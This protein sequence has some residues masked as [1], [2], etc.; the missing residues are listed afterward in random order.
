MC[1]DRS[2][3]ARGATVIVAH[4]RAASRSRIGPALAETTSLTVGGTL[5]GSQLHP[6]PPCVLLELVE[7]VKHEH[8]APVRRRLVEGV[9][10]PHAEGSRIAGAGQ[11]QAQALVQLRQDAPHE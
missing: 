9:G 3:G 4:E 5:T 1:A 7:A 8:E 2:E 6:A 10:E 11:A